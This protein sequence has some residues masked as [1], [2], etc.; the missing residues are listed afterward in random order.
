MAL[1][2]LAADEAR[3]LFAYS[4]G[5]PLRPDERAAADRLCVDAANSPTPHHRDGRDG[6]VR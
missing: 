4:L 1:G 3:A 6:A 5:R 2:G